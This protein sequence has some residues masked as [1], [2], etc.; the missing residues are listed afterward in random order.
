MD[1]DVGVVGSGSFGIT[2]SKLVSENNN[3]LLYA[4]NLETI[5]SINDHHTHLGVKLSERIRATNDLQEV[6]FACDLILPA[7]PSSAFREVMQKMSPYLHP[8]HI[9]IHATKGLELN[10]IDFDHL[11]LVRLDRRDIYTMSEVILEETNVVRVGCLSGPNLAKEILANLPAAAVIA[12]DFD[13]V[14]HYGQKALAS[15]SFSVYASHDIKGAELAGAFKNIIAIASGMLAG[16]G[17]GKNMEALLITRGLNEMISFG[18]K[19]GF[20]G[21]AFLGTAGIGDLI[22]TATSDK[23]RNYTFGFRFARGE[24]MDEIMSTSD[25]VVEGIRTLKILYH[26]C[27]NEKIHIP[28]T[29][30]LYKVVYEEY[31]F[32]KGLEHLM[33]YPFTNDVDFSVVSE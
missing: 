10:K 33:S 19:L 21:Q 7:L 8:Y 1:K 25:E 31:P 20:S 32:K 15:K 18:M 17:M 22:A 28:I 23:S 24:S 5:K 6:C 14:I 9:M 26:F 29:Q 2:I 27:K 11:N 3:V 13:E 30:M 4:R 16:A 12:S